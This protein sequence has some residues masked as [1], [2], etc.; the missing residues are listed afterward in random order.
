MK[1]LL[2]TAA[3]A[4]LTVMAVPMFTQAQA[5]PK[6]PYC[7]LARSEKNPMSWDQYYG[8]WNRQAR[9]ARLMNYAPA[10]IMNR[11][12]IRQTK[13]PYCNL[14]K[15]EKNPMA[16]DQYYHCWGG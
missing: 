10:P 8:C 5:A 7:S 16:W 13:S 12:A 2:I 9:P 1:K 4:G 15:S 14:A 3:A 11:P 6:N